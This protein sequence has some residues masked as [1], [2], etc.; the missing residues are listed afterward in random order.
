MTELQDGD[1]RVDVNEVSS[2]SVK[3]LCSPG[4]SESTMNYRDSPTNVVEASGESLLVK[5]ADGIVCDAPPI[6]N[7]IPPSAPSSVSHCAACSFHFHHDTTTSASK[8]QR[9]LK[10]APALSQQPAGDELCASFLLACLF[11]R[12]E[13]C[14]SAAAEGLQHCMGCLCSELCS[15]LCCFDPASMEQLLEIFP[16]CDLS[17]CVDPHICFCGECPMC[18]LCM[19]ATE[20]L[21]LGMEVSQLLFH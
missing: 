10:T 5:N 17:S 4:D 11:C 14:V 20:C 3:D 16:S 2:T 18:E 12:A 1:D 7:Q 8:S 15:K 21:E 13:E 9:S 6:C 19:Q